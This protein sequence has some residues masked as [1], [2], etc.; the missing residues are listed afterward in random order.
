MK[1]PPKYI[2]GDYSSNSSRLS[3]SDNTVQ[4]DHHTGGAF[5][6]LEKSL[7]SSF[8]HSHRTLPTKPHQWKMSAPNNP[9]YALVSDN[10][11]LDSN[12]EGTEQIEDVPD[13]PLALV[14]S[15]DFSPQDRFIIEHFLRIFERE[16]IHHPFLSGDE[17]HDSSLRSASVGICCQFCVMATAVNGSIAPGAFVFPKNFS[18][19]ELVDR[20]EGEFK[21][22][23]MNCPNAPWVASALTRIEVGDTPNNVWRV[24][25]EDTGIIEIDHVE[26]VNGEN[27]EFKSLAFNPTIYGYPFED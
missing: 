4:L 3:A 13:P 16:M 23:C 7:I 5:A 6:D 9:N 22:H 18:N 10:L 24:A 20:I 15:S 1:V 11:S 25:L 27:V 12:D 26:K 21:V 14:S 19:E 17:H 8:M 2:G